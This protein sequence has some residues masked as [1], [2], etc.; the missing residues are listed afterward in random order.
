M[1]I[2]HNQINNINL[3]IQVF[4]LANKYIILFEYGRF[5]VNV[6]PFVDAA[7]RRVKYRGS[8]DAISW[9]KDLRVAT[10]AAIGRHDVEIPHLARNS[11]GFPKIF[12]NDLNEKLR[13]GDEG[14]IRF[15]LTMLQLSRF[16]EGQ[17]SPDYT[18]ITDPCEI[19][20]EFWKEF[21]V[22]LPQAMKELKLEPSDRP[23]WIA[24]HFTSK[25][26]PAGQAMLSLESDLN[27][28]PESTFQCIGE[29][30]GQNLLD[31]MTQLKDNPD[32][33]KTT[34]EPKESRRGRLRSL[35]LVEDTE[36]KTRVVAMADYWTQ[37]S[38]VPLHER[39]LSHL[40]K[41]GSVDLT[42]GQ[43]ISPFG[44]E[45]EPYYSYDLTS[46]TDRLPRFLYVEVLTQIFGK[47]YAK[48]WEELLVSHPFESPDGVKRIYATGQPM[49]VYSSW[50]L[51]ALVHHVIVR[52]SALRVGKTRFRSYRI[53]GDDIVIRN[54]LVADEYSKVLRYLHVKISKTKTLVSLDTFEFAKRL[55]TKGIE[56]TAVPIHGMVSAAKTSWLDL[57][58]VL[59]T[60]SKRNTS[61]LSWLLW[62]R[63][64]PRLYKI[65][66]HPTRIGETALQLIRTANILRF[67]RAQHDYFVDV[68]RFWGLPVSC[69]TS[70]RSVVEELLNRYLVQLTSKLNESLY[71]TAKQL[72]QTF[73]LEDLEERAVIYKTRDPFQARQIQF[74]DPDEFTEELREP[75]AWC[76]FHQMERITNQDL[77]P[78]PDAEHSEMLEAWTE[79][80][81]KANVR[82]L[83]PRVLDRSRRFE[84]NFRLITSC[85]TKA[86]AFEASKQ[87]NL[88]PG[89]LKRN[90]LRKSS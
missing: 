67:P 73:G 40:R 41:L 65:V 15:T 23:E 72:E 42:F 47:N 90:N 17:K 16:L 44:N 7:I 58:S 38:L 60:A 87:N 43:D 33:F 74:P 52:I 34:Q 2:Y 51:L 64:V 89:H 48:A 31:Y 36:A 85:A 39:L 88:L 55:F 6:R 61:E 68:C 77:H 24:P 75:L 79:C 4:N 46:A 29:I 45:S 62:P 22:Y 49:G 12:G 30:G 32:V 5:Q 8:I 59:E 10:Y 35:G 70:E 19:D 63:L 11:H 9:I 76:M 18:P 56:V 71:S 83:D 50:P 20:P 80:V 28:L 13:T 57:Y 14:A 25:G 26:S 3:F 78:M 1:K 27:H 84:R 81:R 53:L 37:T 69:V 54:K 66:G 21:G 82:I 86:F